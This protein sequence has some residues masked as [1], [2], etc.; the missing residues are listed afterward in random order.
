MMD[1]R[2]EALA[3]APRR[4]SS[5]DLCERLHVVFVGHV[6]HGKSTVVGRLLADTGSLPEGKLERIRVLC[7][8]TARPFEYAFVL[9]ALRKERAQ[10]ITIDAA[11][12][13]FKSGAREYVLHDA[14]GHLE[15]LK[16]MVTGASRADAAILVVDALAGV[17]DN[18]RRH[19][20]L[21]SL[22]GLRRVVV[23]INKMDLVQYRHD[24][25]EAVSAECRSIL[26]CVDL[27]PL[28]IIPV[29]GQSGDNIIQKSSR[30]PWFTKET[31]LSA[32][33]DLEGRPPVA[34]GPLRLPVQDV[35]KFTEDGDQRRIIA[36]RN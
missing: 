5:R 4:R 35:Y 31:L 20:Y 11:R 9:D 19:V 14:P 21:L 12:V 8:R 16:N 36:G 27:R 34:D 17:G 25:F 15:F 10:G 7:E 33:D 23:L 26:T 24:V 2:S 18:T 28:T 3:R 30:M 13:F 22:L 1:V 6:D 29:S 32:L